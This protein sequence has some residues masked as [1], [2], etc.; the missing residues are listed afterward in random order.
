MLIVYGKGY[1][2]LHLVAG[3]ASFAFVTGRLVWGFFGTKYVRFGAFLKG[4]RDIKNEFSVFK[5]AEASHSVGHP[6]V[7]GWVMLLLMFCGVGVGVSGFW[8]HF[9]ANGE[10]KEALLKTHEIFANS[11]LAI[12]FIHIQ[13]VM[14]HALTHKDGIVVGMI[15]GKRPAYEQEEIRALTKLQT[16]IALLWFAA[17]GAAVAFAVS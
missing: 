10:T 12:A 17:V 3:F 5:N 14:L 2:K 6:A 8:L 16:A 7:A 11:L 15:D 1:S 9:F 4:V 13:G